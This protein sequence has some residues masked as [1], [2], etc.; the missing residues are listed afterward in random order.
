[1]IDS[2]SKT[3]GKE[4]YNLLLR[5]TNKLATTATNY[6]AYYNVEFQTLLKHYPDYQKFRIKWTLLSIDSASHTGNHAGALF[7]D[8][9]SK[10]NQYD[11][12]YF[13]SHNLGFVNVVHLGTHGGDDTCMLQ[14]VYEN[15]YTTISKPMVTQLRVYFREIDDSGFFTM[16]SDLPNFILKIELQPIYDE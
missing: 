5:S 8:F 6:D 11:N 3:L 7:V 4:T 13:S 2:S 14:H 12:K 16:G 10:I 9:C 15:T 1:M